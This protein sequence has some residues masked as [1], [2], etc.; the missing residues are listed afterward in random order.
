[1]TASDQRDIERLL[2]DFAWFADRGE[3][4]SLSGLFLPDAQLHVGGQE[5]HGREAI[6]QDCLRR[7]SD[8][9]RKVRHVW[10]NLRVCGEGDG[11]ID[12]AAIQLTFEQ[13]GAGI[14]AQL[15][16]NDLLDRFARDADGTWRFARRV[17]SR[18][19]ALEI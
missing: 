16:V 18:A 3:G 10:S 19:M 1:M 12:T 8:P 7:A 17:I 5:H 11:V 4:Q 13:T 9:Q 6:A 15:R 14:K 2:S